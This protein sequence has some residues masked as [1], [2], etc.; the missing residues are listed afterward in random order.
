MKQ[1]SGKQ[2]KEFTNRQWKTRGD[3][4]ATFKFWWKSEKTKRCYSM[5]PAHVMPQIESVARSA[6]LTAKGLVP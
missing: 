4:E 1:E 3:I 5:I 6:F 2:C